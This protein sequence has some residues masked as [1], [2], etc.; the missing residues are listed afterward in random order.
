MTLEESRYLWLLPA[1][2]CFLL[3]AYVS[4]VQASG[5]LYRFARVRKRPFPA[6]VS[7]LLLSLAL[8]ALILALA[9]PRLRYT[10]TV[11]NRSGIDVAIGID[12]SKS[13]LAEDE[14]LPEEGRKLFSVPN[15]LNRA[16]YSALSILA[17]LKGERVGVFM[18]ASKGVSVVPLTNDYGYCQYILKHVSDATISTPGSDLGQAIGTGISLFEESSRT[19]VKSIVL[20]S[21]GEDIGEDSSR[22]HEAAQRAAAK[23]IAIY[24]VATGSGQ[25]VMIPI[26]DAIGGG[27]EG[28]YQ[29]E[30]GSYLKTRLEQ[31]SLRRIAATSGGSF[32]RARDERGADGIVGAILKRARTIEYTRS[33]EPA[34]YDLSPLLLCGA[35]LLLALAVAV[36]R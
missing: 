24:T 36:G 35:V 16:R 6:V 33:T 13:M 30:D 17:A 5:W 20:I 26:R 7:A 28:Y 22:M 15:R 34:W 19:S 12:V 21:D 27:I 4:F 25:G 3:G 29:D 31:E 2:P 8:A 14:T 9:G 18:F 1:I 10:K 11:F 32:F 23:G